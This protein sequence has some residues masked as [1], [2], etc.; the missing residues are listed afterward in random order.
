MDW[1]L[2]PTLIAVVQTGSLSGAARQLGVSQPTV[3]RHVAELE[4]QLCA[5]L[6]TRSARGLDPT[7]MALD[8]V[9]KAGPMQAAAADIALYAEGRGQ[10]VDGT[11]RITASEV[12]AT[13]ILPPILRDLLIAEPGIEVEVVATNSTA[14]LSLREADVAV[15]MVEPSQQDLI[16]R[17]LG[18]L[19]L[20]IFAHDSYVARAGVPQ[21]PRDLADHVFIGYDR[22]DLMIRAMQAMGMDAH[23]HMFRYRTD[24]QIS[25]VEAICAG[26]GLGATQ[27]SLVQDRP[28][29]RRVLAQL[30]IPGLPIWL[31][32]H[33]ELRTSARVRRVFDY[34]ADALRDHVLHQSSV[35]STT[36]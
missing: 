20:G 15:R 16:A 23:R 21:E 12:A 17:K 26:V 11:V 10:A 7:P 13:Y 2:I 8:I 19:E 27:A 3:G 35:R 32:A 1:N 6:F 9:E 29:V 28:G 36:Q 30:P 34:L 18:E 33:Q 4:T 22:D 31:A 25:H 5:V 14:N 24:N